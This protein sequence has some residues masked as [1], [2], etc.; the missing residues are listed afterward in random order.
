[1]ISEPVS[2]NIL[3]AIISHHNAGI[4]DELSFT[5]DGKPIDR[6]AADETGA[7]EHFAF[8]QFVHSQCHSAE[9]VQAKLEYLLNGTVGERDTLLSFLLDSEYGD[10]L[11]ATFFRS[12]IVFNRS[13]APPHGGGA[14]IPG[15]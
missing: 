13:P 3:D 10:E 4:V 1:M 8:R 15:G 5:D 2:P 9:D 11:A 14:T 6:A 12:L 7:L